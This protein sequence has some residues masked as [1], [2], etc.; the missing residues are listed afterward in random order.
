MNFRHGLRQIWKHEGQCVILWKEYE[1]ITDAKHLVKEEY[2]TRSKG[3]MT[4]VSSSNTYI[5]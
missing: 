1:S 4:S 3:L 5:Y 2:N